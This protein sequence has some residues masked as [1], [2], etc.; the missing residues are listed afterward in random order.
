M[1]YDDPAADEQEV[2]SQ[3]EW[4][5]TSP[6]N[7][8]NL[9]EPMGSVPNDSIRNGEAALAALP[10]AEQV[11]P[12]PTALATASPAEVCTLSLYQ[13]DD[14][15]APSTEATNQHDNVTVPPERQDAVRGVRGDTKGNKFQV[16][17]WTVERGA[18]KNYRR[19]GQALAAANINLYRRGTDAGGL[20]LVLKTGKTRI[21]TKA[22]EFAP[23]IA[24]S[25]TVKVTKGGKV[26][27]DSI[28]APHLSAMLYSDEFL[29][30]F[31]PVDV[32]TRLP[33][34]RADFSLLK[35]GYT[36]DGPGH[37]FL[38]LGVAPQI[39]ESIDT[40]TRFL[41]V[42][43][44]DSNADRTNAVAAAL[45]L[46][47]RHHW[48]GAKPIILVTATKS[49]AGKGT[50]TDFIRGAVPKADILY[51]SVDWPMH[52]QFHR[53]LR[54]DQ[55]VGLICFDNVRQDSAGSSARMIRSAFIESLVTS[56]EITLSSPGAGASVHF[57]NRL[58][59]TIN[60]NQGTFSSD[61]LNRALSIHLAPKGN[62]HDRQSPIGNPKL[63]F[64][65]Q[66]RER[67]EAE[68]RGMIERWK[69]AGRPLDEKAKHPMTPWAKTVGGIL[70]ESGFTD[71][72]ANYGSR[73]AADDPI[74]EALAILAAAMPAKQLRPREWAKQ[75]VDQGLAKTLFTANDR[76]TVA[77]RERAIGSI[78]KQH[79]EETFETKTETTKLLMRLDG[80]NRRWLAGKNPHVRY[81]FTVLS[82]TPFPVTE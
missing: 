5:T 26:T 29:G 79:L 31:R 27:S 73:K 38:Y 50:V 42:I 3:A 25:L 22:S 76:D 67:I 70:K 53:Q 1:L 40:I 54:L 78:L 24:D 12:V 33:L 21:I 55:E 81:V 17:R 2:A 14:L 49:H 66:N 4:A 61:L 69:E 77:G 51:E 47:L 43:A 11:M 48:L 46:L 65:P 71:F 8:N 59:V 16:F 58:M 74:R 63:E 28:S 6:A 34:Y 13:P 41:D 44:F 36:D 68:L 62:V 37:R 56:P 57:Q 39:A 72:L 82:S 20:I 30:H 75:A 10:A 35:P 45:S 7:E 52:N 23:V 18:R 32:L 80:G 60:A 15:S 19:F 9:T 64:L